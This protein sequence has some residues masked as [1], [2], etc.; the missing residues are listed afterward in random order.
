MVGA[1][2]RARAMQSA[3]AAAAGALLPEANV[4]WSF[5]VSLA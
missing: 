3:A 5:M 1:S 4:L 2:E